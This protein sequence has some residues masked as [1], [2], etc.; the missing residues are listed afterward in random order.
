MPGSER[1]VL[2]GVAN[3]V[4]LDLKKPKRPESRS[5][6]LFGNRKGTTGRGGDM[7]G[8]PRCIRVKY[9]FRICKTFRMKLI[10]LHNKHAPT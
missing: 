3:T 1:Q 8:R 9:M 4:Y 7:K 10:I 6:K 5:V 2:H